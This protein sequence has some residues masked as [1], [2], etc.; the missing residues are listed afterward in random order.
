M[1]KSL[2]VCLSASLSISPTAHYVYIGDHH[3]T[4]WGRVTH[5]CVG[6]III[7]GSDNGFSPRRCQAIIWTNAKILSIG[8]LG[9]NFSEIS[10]EINISSFK[11]MPLKMLSAKF[12]PSCL[13][14]CVKRVRRWPDLVEWQL[15]ANYMSHSRFHIFCYILTKFLFTEF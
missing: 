6:N 10:I 15:H 14:L 9:T 11:K 4:H 2:F 7:I 12:R 13:G 3:L 8:S 1:T 5:T